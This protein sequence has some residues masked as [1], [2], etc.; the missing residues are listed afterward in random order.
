MASNYGAVAVYAPLKLTRGIRQR[1]RNLLPVA[2][3]PDLVACN[4][5]GPS[6]TS[7]I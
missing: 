4:L 1:E 7:T 3:D 6:K 5:G 2:M